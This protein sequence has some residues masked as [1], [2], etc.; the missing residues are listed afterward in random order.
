MTRKFFVIAASLVAVGALIYVAIGRTL[1]LRSAAASNI[2]RAEAAND[3]GSGDKNEP[4]NFT[5]SDDASA[6]DT[7]IPAKRA[8]SAPR[9]SKARAG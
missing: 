7:F 5:T 6:R 1:A 9:S 2:A 3:S 8:R 4:A